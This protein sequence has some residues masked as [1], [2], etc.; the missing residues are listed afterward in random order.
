MPMKF[1]P[2]IL[3]SLILLT[4]SVHAGKL[5]GIT[6]NQAQL[7]IT[8]NGKTI[9]IVRNQD[10]QNKLIGAYAKTSRPCPPYCLQPISAGNNV[11]LIGEVELLQL[12]KNEIVKE[13][14]LLIDVRGPEWFLIGSLPIAVNFPFQSLKS[15]LTDKS[16]SQLQD[17][18]VNSIGESFVSSV[19]RNKVLST[20][21]GQKKLV[22][23][24]NGHWSPESRKAIEL[25][26]NS[27]Y[28]AENI[29]WYRGGVQNWV[30]AGLYLYK[31]E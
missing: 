30:Q 7:V 3:L 23:F 24:C 31:S 1:T 20:V 15:A 27:G 22:V 9:T 8:H 13:D 25:L 17:L 5:V 11:K 10:N 28:P 2:R 4:G 18:A 29:Y 16:F 14:I 12:Y 21:F 26:I 19:K 6:K